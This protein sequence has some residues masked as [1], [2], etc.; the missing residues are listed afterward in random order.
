MA[1]DNVKAE[2]RT[3]HSYYSRELRRKMIL[4]TA[5]EPPKRTNLKM[6]LLRWFHRV[7]NEKR[8]L[9]FIERGVF[10]HVNC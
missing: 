6:L 5:K 2:G 1:A 8:Y 4:R 10:F 3:L 7:T 9:R